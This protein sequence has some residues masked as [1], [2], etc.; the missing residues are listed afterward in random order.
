MIS[1]LFVVWFTLYTL[2]ETPQV[3]SFSSQKD[4]RRRTSRL[5][6]YM[7]GTSNDGCTGG[8]CPEMV[9]QRRNFI[10]ALTAITA[11]NGLLDHVDAALAEEDP[12]SPS[13]STAAAAATAA[14]RGPIE[15]LR[16]ATRVRLYIDNA[17]D[18]CRKIKKTATGSD[19]R[20]KLQQLSDL[21]LPEQSFTTSEES[22]LARTYLEI[23]TTSPWQAARLQER[24]QRGKERGIDYSTPYD[25]VNTAIQE[26][27]DRRQFEL[28]QNR[29]R[30]LESKNEIRAAFNAYTNNI[31]FSDSYKLN[32]DGEN[33]KVLVRNDALPDV[34]AVVVSDLDLRDLY[35]NQVLQNVDDAKSELTYQLKQSDDKN[36]DVDEILEYLVA[37]QS[38]C[39]EWFSFIPEEDRDAARRAV[40][41]GQ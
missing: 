4:V 33:K 41:D 27:G 10:V 5:Q 15:L 20:E 24:V 32:V 40:L 39:N 16:P 31:V 13:T 9:I 30:K 11:G 17:I 1:F 26:W 8:C 6:R 14:V 3:S 35:R 34:N 23:D 7:V 18:T 22:K 12:A 25:K 2:F 29:Q 38:A 19:I 21:F 37:A 28:L 36:I